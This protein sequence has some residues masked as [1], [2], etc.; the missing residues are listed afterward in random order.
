MAEDYGA[1]SLN[2]L[3][4]ALADVP[5]GQSANFGRIGKD[6]RLSAS[7]VAVGVW[8][9]ISQGRI[10]K[11]T[12]RPPR[13]AAPRAYCQH[14]SACAAE[15]AG[16]CR[17]GCR[18]LAK[19]EPVKLKAK[20]PKGVPTPPPVNPGAQV[21]CRQCDRRVTVD[22]AVNCQSRFCNAEL[23]PQMRECRL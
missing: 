11:E 14:P 8:N 9:L 21:W 13:R 16:A 6:L 15:A 18:P 20:P 19:V 22:K 17:L 2:R 10:D 5:A 12:L 4:A 23:P 3:A 7:E 1:A